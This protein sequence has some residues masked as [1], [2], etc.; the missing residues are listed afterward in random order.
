MQN[1]GSQIKRVLDSKRAGE[2]PKELK[3]EGKNSVNRVI[4]EEQEEEE[5][6]KEYKKQNTKVEEENSIVQFL[7]Q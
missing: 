5:Q 3:K 6:T 2:E 1:C 7:G 4:E